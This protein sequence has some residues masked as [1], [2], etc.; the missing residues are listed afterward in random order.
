MSVKKFGSLEFRALDSSLDIDRMVK[1]CE[2]LVNIRDSS[3]FY[4]TPDNLLGGI[5][6]EGYLQFATTMLKK[7]YVD[8]FLTDGWIKKI[9]KGIIHAQE[10]AYSKDW[11][12]FSLN[13]FKKSVF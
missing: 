5:S 9:R 4:R 8:E 12:A 3:I 6:N 13:I 7:E 10:I 1:W 11:K 2:I